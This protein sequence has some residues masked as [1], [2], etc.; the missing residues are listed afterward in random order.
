MKKYKLYIVVLSGLLMTGACKLDNYN[1]PSATLYGAFIDVE[2]GGL[3]EQD[4][5]RGT[6][7]EYVE[8]GYAAKAKEYMVV[9]NDG[10]YRNT[11]LF[12]N[13]YEI[14]PVRGN[15]AAVAP[16]EINISGQTQLD[17]AVLP[18]IRVKDLDIKKN[19]TKIVATFKLQQTINKPIS[20]VGIYAH[21]DMSVGASLHTALAEKS[22][23]AVADSNQVFILELDIAT[24][25]AL[26]AGKPYFFR[27]GALIDVPEARFNYAK[28]VRLTP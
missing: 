23:N 12:P 28:S 18:Y 25:P 6:T 27:V 1:A 14:T 3:V 2:R 15:F 8:A 16:Q 26:T 9:K 19:G 10:T 7:I 21:P 4:I 20:R 24:T 17:F 13:Q 22:I 5:I 11:M